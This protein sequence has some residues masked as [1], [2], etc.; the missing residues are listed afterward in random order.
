MAIFTI[1]TFANFV[2]PI[3]TTVTLFHATNTNFVTV[4]IKYFLELMNPPKI[5]TTK[6]CRNY[7]C[8]VIKFVELQIRIFFSFLIIFKQIFLDTGLSKPTCDK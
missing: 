7:P 1:K 6:F 4:A 8:A 5:Y 3:V 2:K